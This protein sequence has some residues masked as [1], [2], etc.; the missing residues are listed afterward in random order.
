VP[1]GV[2]SLHIFAQTVRIS[3]GQVDYRV[4]VCW[5]VGR[6]KIAMGCCRVGDGACSLVQEP[7]VAKVGQCRESFS[8]ILF[9]VRGNKKEMQQSGMVQPNKDVMSV[10]V[11]WW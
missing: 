8:T 5:V 11:G 1:N 10:V 2:C 4:G 7:Q 6:L 9:G 3:V